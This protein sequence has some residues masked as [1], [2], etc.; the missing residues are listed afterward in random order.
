M[1]KTWKDVQKQK[2]KSWTIMALFALLIV[3]VIQGT[4]KC[5]RQLCI[6]YSIAPDKDLYRLYSYFSAKTY[7]MLLIKSASPK[8][9]TTNVF[10]EK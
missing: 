1:A 3:F 9:N 2:Y 7:V 4:A 6:I 8:S 10:V 5:K